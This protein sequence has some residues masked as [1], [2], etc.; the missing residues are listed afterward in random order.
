MA[1][2]LVVDVETT[3][4]N[5]HRNQ[6][7]TLGAAVFDDSTSSKEPLNT[8]SEDI[9]ISPDGEI[10]PIA[11]KVNKA[12]LDN[13]SLQFVEEKVAINKFV[14]YVWNIEKI[15]YL[16]GFNIQFDL[17]FLEQAFIRSRINFVNFL[18]YKVIDP[19]VLVHTLIQTGCLPNLKYTNLKALCNH[20]GLEAS[21]SHTALGDIRNTYLLY[22]EMKDELAKKFS[23]KIR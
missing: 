3:G 11:L 18:P 21:D 14:D 9:V 15:D 16:M 13:S 17:R 5:P 2:Y 22:L 10:D 20:Y 12:K 8:F 4:L 1:H 7:L 23:S 19:F 6:I